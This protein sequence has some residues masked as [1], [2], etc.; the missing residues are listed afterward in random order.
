MASS[1]SSSAP[2][3]FPAELAGQWEFVKDEHLSG[4]ATHHAVM[5]SFDS[6]GYYNTLESRGTTNGR[7][8][9][10]MND[11][12]YGHA[13][14]HGPTLTLHLEKHT[15][16]TDN[17]CNGTKLEAPKELDNV[18]YQYALRQNPDGQELCLNGRFGETCFR[19]KKR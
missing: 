5:F 7:C 2:T 12:S 15:E 8:Y 9:T 14:A 6:N 13:S 18:V 10:L 19:P 17:T 4:S 1:L 11:G 3:P 16:S